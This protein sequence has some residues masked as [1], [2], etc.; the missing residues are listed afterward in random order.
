M[1]SRVWFFATPWTVAR[2]APLSMGFFQ[3]RI[4]QWV[5]ISFSRGSSQPR[6]RTCGSRIGRQILY[7]WAAREAPWIALYYHLR[8]SEN[9]L[10][11][12]PAKVKFYFTSHVLAGIS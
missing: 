11:L 10:L 5:A 8:N 7:H 6:D 9:F 3:A 2:Q 1:L 4:L 12:F